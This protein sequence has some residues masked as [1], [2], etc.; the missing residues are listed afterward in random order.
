MLGPG[1]SATQAGLR[2]LGECGCPV[3]WCGEQCVRM[4]SFSQPLSGNTD[5][6]ERQPSSAPTRAAGCGW[7]QGCLRSASNMSLPHGRS[8]TFAAGGHAYRC[9]VVPRSSGGGGIAW[10][11]RSDRPGLGRAGRPESRTERRGEAAFYAV[12][13]AAVLA[14]G[15]APSRVHSPGEPLALAYDLADL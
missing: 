15:L 8:T 6:L 4:Y 5:L 9:V 13:T 1:A 7:P 14:L 3:A 2:A 12:C 10:T 11:G